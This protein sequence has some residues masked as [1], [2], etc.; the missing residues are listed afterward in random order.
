[1]PAAKAIGRARAHDVVEHASATAIAER[2]H[3]GDVLKQDKALS[4]HLAAAEIDRLLD[5]AFYVGE[6]EAVVDRV[7]AR[8]RSLLGG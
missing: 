8:A 1:M 7:A 5:P 3:L 2:R 6:S 4:G